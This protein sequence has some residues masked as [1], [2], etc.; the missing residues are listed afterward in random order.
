MAQEID[1][2]TIPIDKI[3]IIRNTLSIQPNVT[4]YNRQARP[5][6]ITFYSVHGNI[7]RLPYIYY[8]GLFGTNA[9]SAKY[10]P[11]VSIK[12][13]GQLRP[14]QVDVIVEALEQMHKFGSTTLGLYPGFGKTI[15]GAKLASEVGLLTCVLVHREI[16]T[17]QWR[18]TFTQFTDAQC[19]IVGERDPPTTCSVII[20][21]DTRWEQIPE[22]LR[23]SIGV[24]IIDEAHAFCT[25]SH[26]S[27]ILAFQPRY[28]ILESAS[29]ERDDGLHAMM[30]AVAGTHGIYRETS[31]PFT[32]LK[33]NTNTRPERKMTKMGKTDWSALVRDILMDRRRNDLILSLI[34]DNRHRKILVLTSMVDHAHLLYND[35]LAMGISC[36]ILCGTKKGYI[37]SN[38]LFGTMSKIG[39]GFDPAT[40]CPTYD[41]KPFDLLIIVS[42]IKK[43]SMLIQNVGRAFRAEYPVVMHLVDDDSIIKSHWYVCRKWYLA[44][45][46]TIKAQ[47]IHNPE[48]L[49]AEH[50]SQKLQQW[51]KSRAKTLPT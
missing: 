33:I 5:P 24:L 27:C 11:P 10:Y 41:G 7:V 2:T 51:V 50:E 45:G 42:S 23:K 6:P 16:L 9:S 40:S 19:W 14:I 15:L 48:P 17:T 28:V 21:M 43:Y 18:T 44:R 22:E 35:A 30:Y 34:N 8:T 4:I 49:P 20:C 1:K 46:A 13:T 29:I 3:N 39:T 12:F 31:K 38:V 32:V 47:D 25:T 26:V 37:D 36:D